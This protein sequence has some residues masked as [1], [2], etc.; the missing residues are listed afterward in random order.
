[1]VLKEDDS[2]IEMQANYLSPADLKMFVNA[3]VRHHD[4][5]SQ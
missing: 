1:M 3:P 4:V 2:I 5:M